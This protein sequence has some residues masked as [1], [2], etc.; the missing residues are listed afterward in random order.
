[1]TTPGP[2][3]GNV[4]RVKRDWYA[5]GFSFGVWADP[6]GQVWQNYEHDSDELVMLT[7]GVI[8]IEMQEK[9]LRPSVGEEVLIPGK[10]LHTVR[11]VG[12]TM[13]CWL[14]GYRTF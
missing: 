2:P 5:R 1:M 8:E 11:N 4:D 13:A 12:G 14:Y 6:P 7:E 10:V 3:A 9:V